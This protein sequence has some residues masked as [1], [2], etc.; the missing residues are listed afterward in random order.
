MRQTNDVNAA[1]LGN[2]YKKCYERPPVCL[3]VGTGDDR[4]EV[5]VKHRLSAD[6][7]SAIVDNVCAG[8]I[9]S[10]TGLLHPELKDYYL[11]RSVLESYTNLKL[12]EETSAWDLVY[13]TPIF[14]MVTGNCKRPVIF[15]GFEYDDNEVIDVEQYEQLVTTIDQ[16]I[17]YAMRQHF[18]NDLIK[19]AKAS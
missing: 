15:D 9:D 11:R 3:S 1:E 6:E 12:P 5:E 2:L 4:M 18:L 13:G 8:V 10:A 17:E 19:V 16:K 14:A 7:M